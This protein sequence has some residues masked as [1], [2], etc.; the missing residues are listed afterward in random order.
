MAVIY[1][2]VQSALENKEGNKL[3]YPRVQLV[4][5]VSTD[6]I[7]KEI[8]ELSSLTSGDTKNVIDNLVTVM[9]RHLAASESVTLDGLGSFRYTL[10]LQSGKGV[11]AA[12]E[13]SSSQA[14]LMVRFQPTFTRKTD[15]TVATRTLTDDVQFVHIDKLLG[16]SATTSSGSTDNGSTDSGDEEEEV[17]PFG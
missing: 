9:K 17:N 3:F 6:T 16:A 5:N 10:K 8:A 14:S 1:K 7:A 13:V 2:S 11:A 15:G 4:G 12:E